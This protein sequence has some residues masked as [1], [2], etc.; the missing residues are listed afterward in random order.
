MDTVKNGE[1]LRNIIEKVWED[2]TLLR[3]LE[4][5]AAVNEVVEQ[6]DRGELRAAEPVGEGG[7]RVNDWV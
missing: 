1:E 4:A 3:N 7:W 5:Q 6:L 2:H